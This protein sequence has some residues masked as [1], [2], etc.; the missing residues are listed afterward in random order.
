MSK[1]KYARAVRSLS[2]AVTNG[3]MNEFEAIGVLSLAQASGYFGK[4]PDTDTLTKTV[5]AEK[6]KAMKTKTSPAALK[7]TKAGALFNG[8][9]V[10]DASERLSDVKSVVKGRDG[11]ALRWGAKT[12]ETASERDNATVGVWFKH[13]LKRAGVPGIVFS[14]W[15][16]S[17]FAEL[18]Q[19]GRWVGEAAGTY[20]GGGSPDDYVPNAVVKS[21]L[22]DTTSGGIYLNPAVFDAN[23]ITYPLLHSELLPFIDLVPVTGRRVQGATMGN[24]SLTWGSAAGQAIQPLNTS[25][26]V[27]DL[28]TPVFP[29]SGAIEIGNDLLADS[30]V[31][32]GATVTGLYG[33]KQKAELDR[34]VVNGNGTNEPAGI[35]NTSGLVTVSSDNGAGGPPTVSDYEGLLFGVGKQYRAKDWNPVFIGNDTSYRRARGIPVGAGDERRVFGMDHETYTLLNHR[36]AISNDLSN[37]KVVFGCLKRFRLYQAHG[38]EVVVERG[39]RQLALT[40]QTLIVLRSRFG[41][42]VVDANSFAISTDMQS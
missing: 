14:E 32:I 23:V 19:K 17:L 41:G 18:V 37:A 3:A 2:W 35:T 27:G 31:N 15:E 38:T 10:K 16:K 13:T 26:L 33:E 4:S 40:N 5:R 39:G 42:K 29:L 8:A 11:N 34:V 28:S 1:R 6:V 20:Y 7:G 12:V 9:R 36:Y 21:L 22:D 25:S 30:P 24:M